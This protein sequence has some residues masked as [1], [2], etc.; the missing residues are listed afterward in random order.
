MPETACNNVLTLFPDLEDITR[1]TGNFKKFS[2]FVKMLSTALLNKSDSVFV[3]LLTFTDLVM[4]VIDILTS[5][6]CV[7]CSDKG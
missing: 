3:D 4:N 6:N 1:K 2:L 7:D 5:C